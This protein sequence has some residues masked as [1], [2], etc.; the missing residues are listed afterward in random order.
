MDDYRKDTQSINLGVGD[1]LIDSVIG[2]VGV[3]IEIEKDHETA[4]YYHESIFWRVYWISL[5]PQSDFAY[6]GPMYT[7]EYGLK[8]SILIGIYDPYPID[9]NK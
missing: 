1:L 3:L 6:S 5:N 8:M 2:S 9:C 4:G 7:E